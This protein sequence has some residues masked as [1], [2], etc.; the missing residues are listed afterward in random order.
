[1]VQ[2]D[3]GATTLVEP[4]GRRWQVRVTEATRDLA[5]MQGEI[6][7]VEGRARGRRL[8]ASTYVLR[9]GT[10]GL[11]AFSGVLGWEDGV[12]GLYDRASGWF[13]RLEGPAARELVNQ[14]GTPIVAEGY[15]EGAR[16]LR[17]VYYRVL[18]PVSAA[19]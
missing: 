13:L 8:L 9:E 19:P 11:Q 12:L 16:G 2:N 10:H 17:V 3:S 14:V 15:S 18:A 7:D 4:E 6:V 1:M 5:W